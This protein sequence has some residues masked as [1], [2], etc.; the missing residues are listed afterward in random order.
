MTF[1]I[2]GLDLYEVMKASGFAPFPVAVV[3]RYAEE[4]LEALSAVHGAGVVHCDVKP[5]NVLCVDGSKGDV[6]LIDFGSG[7]FDGNQRY[8]YIQSRF[9]R[10]PEVVLGMWYG[11]PMDIWSLAL[12]VVEML[13]GRP[14]F[15]ADDEIELI[16]MIME[17]FGP[18]PAAMVRASRRKNE[19]FDAQLNLAKKHK[20]VRKP[21]S[22][23]L[24]RVVKSADPHLLDFL[25]KCLAWDPDARPTAQQALQHPWIRVPE[26]TGSILPSMRH[27]IAVS[28]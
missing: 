24:P 23:S 14:M 27:S 22:V 18:P 2:L 25:R 4:L 11:P 28:G 19:L 20:N 8:Q 9:Y 10:A 17:V 26:K 21:F 13:T 6:K 16:G 7:C 1:E 15:P 12:I 3:R 5:E